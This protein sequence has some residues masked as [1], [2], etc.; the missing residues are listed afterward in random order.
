VIWTPPAAAISVAVLSESEALHRTRRTADGVG[1]RCGI[2]RIE[3]VPQANRRL[4]VT[5]PEDGQ[6]GEKASA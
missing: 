4:G 6:V 1:Q 5:D 2:G 3:H